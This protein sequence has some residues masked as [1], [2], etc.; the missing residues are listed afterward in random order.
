MK[1]RNKHTAPSKRG[2]DIELFTTTSNQD[3]TQL[4]FKRVRMRGAYNK[5]KHNT[6][7]AR[8]LKKSLINL[9]TKKDAPL[10]HF[11]RP[12]APHNTNEFLIANYRQ[13]W[14]EYICKTT[15][16]TNDFFSLDDDFCIAG[17]TMKGIITSQYR[18]LFVYPESMTSTCDTDSS[19]DKDTQDN[20]P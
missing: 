2:G 3:L 9:T 17:G 14:D 10:P 5:I 8:S 20:V 1:L 15:S 11:T 12:S 6:T 16:L 4:V 7:S 19:Y 18:Q 13:Q